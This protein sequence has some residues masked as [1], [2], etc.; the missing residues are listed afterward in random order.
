MAENIDFGN[1]PLS[2]GLNIGRFICQINWICRFWAS[3]P[4]T[5]KRTPPPTAPKNVH[6]NLAKQATWSIDFKM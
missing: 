6:L 5:F 4:L 1:P 2:K 3:N